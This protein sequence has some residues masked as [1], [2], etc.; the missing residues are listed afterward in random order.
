MSDAPDP[1]SLTT[2]IDG[3]ALNREISVVRDDADQP[4]GEEF[5]DAKEPVRGARQDGVTRRG[6][7]TRERTK[8]V[9][10]VWVPVRQS[11]WKCDPALAALIGAKR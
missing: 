11:I 8:C 6:V 2:A 4:R 1:P 10:R 3:N 9:D 7:T 5:D